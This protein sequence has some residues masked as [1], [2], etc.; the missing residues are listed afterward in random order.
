MSNKDPKNELKGFID[1]ARVFGFLAFFIGMLLIASIDSLN[2]AEILTV[3]G[4]I[5][6]FFWVSAS[7]VRKA[8][9]LFDGNRD[10]LLNK[11]YNIFDINNLWD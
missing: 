9:P 3:G 1:V 5:G 10:Q 6:F 8:E 4:V 7:A 2:T 11:I